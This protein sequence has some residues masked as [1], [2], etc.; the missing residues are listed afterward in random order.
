[1]LDSLVAASESG[2]TA[3]QVSSTGEYGRGSS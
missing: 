3:P 1:L 2:D